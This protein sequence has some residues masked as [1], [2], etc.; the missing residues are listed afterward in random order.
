MSRLVKF[1]N[2]IDSLDSDGLH[3]QSST[4]IRDDVSV[5]THRTARCPTSRIGSPS[6]NEIPE[7]D[8]PE[9]SSFSNKTPPLPPRL[10]KLTLFLSEYNITNPL[11]PRFLNGTTRIPLL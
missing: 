5:T 2:K 9:C 11:L 10:E 3:S 8:N 6:M 4:R 1:R 7:A